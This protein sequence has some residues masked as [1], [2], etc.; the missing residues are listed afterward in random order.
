MKWFYEVRDLISE[1]N[2]SMR[3]ER[4][5][6][7]WRVFSGGNENTG[8][9]LTNVWSKTYKLIRKSEPRSRKM[10]S[11]LV[12]GLGA[13]GSVKEFYQN[14][15]GSTVTAIEYDPMMISLAKEFRLWHPYA[16]PRIFE[17][18][19]EK[20]VA[21]LTDMF[22]CIVIDLFYKGEPSALL[23][24]NSFVVSL[25]DRLEKDGVIAV[26]TFR[27]PEYMELFKKYFEETGVYRIGNN[28][29]GIF[30]GPRAKDER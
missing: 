4:I 3:T 25:R 13:G 10:S 12:L 15:P 20:V 26:N 7:K 5:L 28:H 27:N 22:D 2:G 17:G 19:A 23:L 21:E 9:E 30:K 24:K 16:S 8:P 11:A 18:D 14:F 1:K 29:V 6:G